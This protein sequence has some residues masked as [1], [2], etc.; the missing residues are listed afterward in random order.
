V[1]IP[2]LTQ[3]VETLTSRLEKVEREGKR[4]AAPFRKK[5][6]PDPKKPGQK[7]GD[8]HGKHNRR[9]VPER[10]DET[11]DVPL[12][13]CCPGSGHNELAKTETLVQYQAEIPRTVIHRQFNFDGGTCCGCGAKVQG[14]HPLQTSDASGDATNWRAEQAIRPAVVNRKAWGWNRSEAGAQAQSIVMSV[15]RTCS[16]RIADPLEFIRH[17]LKSTKVLTP[18]LP[19]VVR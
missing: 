13:P 1:I 9:S 10:I 17:Q 12:P 15:M 14:R 3:Q 8:D 11:Y 2:S 6:K 16:Q 18:P 7:S 19:I 5:I 4:Q